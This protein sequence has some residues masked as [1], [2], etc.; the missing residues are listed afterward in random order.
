[1]GERSSTMILRNLSI[2]GMLTFITMTTSVVA[3]VMASSAFLA[4]DLMEFRRTMRADLETQARVVAANTAAALAYH[5]SAAA[6][7][8]LSALRAKEELEVAVLFSRDGQPF[9]RYVRDS[10]AAGAVPEAPVVVGSRFG[11]KHLVVSHPVVADGA[12]LG[13]LHLQSDLRFWDSR[14]GKYALVLLLLTLGAALAALI[15]SRR[16]QVLIASPVIE[17]MEATKLISQRQDYS[18]RAS[19]ASGGELGALAQGFNAML[20]EIQARDAALLE[21]NGQLR[22]RTVALEEEVRERERAERQLKALNDT[23]EQR[24]ADRSAA[25]EQ[26]ALDLAASEEDV[27]RHTITLQSILHSMGDGVIVAD[28]EGN[29]LLSNPAAEHILHM[30]LSGANRSDWTDR[31]G[32]YLPDMVTPFPVDE[33]PIAQASRGRAVDGA[34]VFMRHAFAPEGMWLS[35]NARPLDQETGSAKGC[36]AV[37][38]DISEAKLAEQEL[39]NARDAAEAAN[40]AKSAFLANMS[41]ELRT[42]LNAILGYSEMLQEEAEAHGHNEYLPDLRKVH[43]AGRHLLS[44]IN[45]VLDLSKIEAGRMELFVESVA[46]ADLIDG[47]VGAVR[48]LLQ[49]NQNQ[50]HVEDDRALGTMRTDLTK[51]R[52]VLLN[53]LTNAA[54]FTDK[55]KVVLETR[56]QAV[57]GLDWIVF[58][59]SDTGIGMTGEQVSRLFREFTQADASTTRK[60]GGTGLG[61][62]ISRR[63]CQM[64]GGRIEVESR[65]GEGST[66][67]VHLPADIDAAVDVT[68]GQ[69]S[70][71][72]PAPT[73]THGSDGRTVLIID[74]DPAARQLVARFLAREG[75]APVWASNGADGLRLARQLQPAV[76]TLDVLMPAMDGWTVLKTLKSDPEL[77]EIPVIML[78]I[79]DDHGLGYAL[80]ASDYLTKPIDGARLAAVVKRHACLETPRPVLVVE[81]DGD[82]RDLLRRRLEGLGCRVVEAENGRVALERLRQARPEV[83]LLDLMMPEMD[84]FEFVLELRRSDAWRDIPVVVVS[85]RELDD[86]DLRRLNGHVA[87]VLQKAGT[88]CHELLPEVGRLVKARLEQRPES[89]V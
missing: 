30:S 20:A 39:V 44:L 8:V 16:L 10:A 1:M 17:L 19:P 26:R 48:P 63:F 57:D 77:A 84:G 33:M 5:D 89:A 64:L 40:R 82:T 18:L 68:P 12:F 14:L 52:Q 79:L 74:D 88:S 29:V 7:E 3:L 36:V 43:I 38:R 13:T 66:F 87:G 67:S 61:L 15:V 50:M 59:V 42:P 31:F 54:K 47:V 72:L 55:G 11:R 70:T 2:R 71:E 35:V 41:H 27:R 53:V 73:P 23:L 81:D 4:Y 69:I 83:I 25:A 60:Y 78:T 65:P 76:I 21:A 86:D 45:D 49:K 6:S 51:V 22:A 75:F 37:I 32:F 24:V 56:R 58:R 62:A 9:S 85:A 46:V 80:G 34:E 28:E